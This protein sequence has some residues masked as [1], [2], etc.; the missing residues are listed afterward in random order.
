MHLDW[1]KLSS[2]CEINTLENCKISTNWWIITLSISLITWIIVKIGRSWNRY[3]NY[4]LTLQSHVMMW[5]GISSNQQPYSEP[6]HSEISNLH[7]PVSLQGSAHSCKLWNSMQ[8]VKQPEHERV[9]TTEDWNI[10]LTDIQV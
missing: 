10:L 9:L 2:N 6:C 3:Q 8:A 5:A 1:L 7:I 4:M